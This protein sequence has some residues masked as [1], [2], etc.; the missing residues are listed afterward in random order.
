MATKIAFFA[1]KDG[2]HDEQFEY[3]FYPGFALAQK[4]KNITAI[5]ESITRRHPDAKI[6]EV[7]R[8][9]DK[10]IGTKLS[11]FNLT[12]DGKPVECIFQSS[13][14]FING[15]HFPFLIDALPG[16]AKKYVKEHSSSPLECFEYEGG[17]Y[18]LSPRSAVYDYI[19]I[20]ALNQHPEIADELMEYDA[21]TDVEFN[22][23]ASINCQAR[24]CAIFVYL[25]RSGS[26]DSYISSFE[27]F[28]SLYGFSDL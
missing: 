28:A 22:Q 5:H 4:R 20:R 13:K 10:P 3:Q 25:K 18:P 16:E 15:D 12:L 6:L 9:S 7:S 21:F 8:R 26:Y 19:Y 11:A 23:N 1:D 27:E 17:R 24:S 14:V 2:F